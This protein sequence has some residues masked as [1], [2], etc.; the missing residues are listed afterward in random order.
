[1]TFMLLVICYYIIEA[2]IIWTFVMVPWK[3]YKLVKK[4]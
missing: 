3:L 4:Q 1:M 2:E